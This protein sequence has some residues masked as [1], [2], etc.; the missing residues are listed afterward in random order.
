MVQPTATTCVLL[1]LLSAAAVYCQQGDDVSS[2]SGL[3]VSA[4]TRT[5]P[6]APPEEPLADTPLTAPSEEQPQAS[7]VLAS[8]PAAEQ[9]SQPP[10]SPAVSTDGSDS[11]SGQ[12]P[13]YCDTQKYRTTNFTDVLNTTDSIS[14]LRP[15]ADVATGEWITG[16]WARAHL[17]PT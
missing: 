9:D 4:P 6:A 1:L 13:P 2:D 12:C 15:R 7:P 14:P 11:G 8:K 5:Q 17:A 3:P 16:R 10:S